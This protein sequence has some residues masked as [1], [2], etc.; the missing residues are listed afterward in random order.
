VI[1]SL[2]NAYI[3]RQVYTNSSS[4][5]SKSPRETLKLAHF[6]IQ[7]NERLP[8]SAEA[9]RP[10]LEYGNRPIDCHNLSH[11]KKSLQQP[12]LQA[13]FLYKMLA[14]GRAHSLPLCFHTAA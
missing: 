13:L 8:Y 1:T 4:M 7:K 2:D 12:T 9:K 11:N 3:V 10:S 14:V 5:S 6:K